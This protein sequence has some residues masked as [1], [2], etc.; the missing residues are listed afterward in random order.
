MLPGKGDKTSDVSEARRARRRGRGRARRRVA[1]PLA[2][3]R[4]GAENALE[5]IRL[6]RLT[7]RDGAHYEV[8]HRDH[9]YRLRHYVAPGAT[10][11]AHAPVLVLVPPLMLTAEI[12]D[13]APELSAV[14]QL[15]VAGVD[16]WV[17]DFGAP[18][19]EEG[20][21]QR[22][23]DD[24][25]RAVADAVGRVR[26]LAGRDVHL[27]GYSQG[28]M[29]AYQAAAFQ[30][31]EGIA[32]IIT[33]GSPVDIHR[34]VPA[35][36][37]ELTARVIRAVR[38]MIEAPLERM[39]GLPGVLTST[40]FKLLSPKKEISQLFDFV[41]K[42]HDRSALEKRETRRRFLA[43][44]GFVAWP[45]PALRQFIDEFIVHNRML[46]GGF[47]IDGRTVTLADIRCPVLCF[48][49]SR[50][51]IARPDAVRAI[52]RAAPSAELSE[53]T[54]PAG[55]FGL[56]VGS[57]AS[58]ETWPAVIEWLRWRDAG[59]AKPPRFASEE[60]G[61]DEPEALAEIED[62]AFEEPLDIE[63][64]YDAARGTIESAW[65]RLAHLI[66][67]AGD[68]LDH[69]RFQLP[70]LNQLGKM[71]DETRT[72]FGLELARQA[73]EIP[74]QTFFIWK[75]RAFSY[76]VADHRVDN[77]V[78]GL[79]HCG[80]RAGDHVGV[81]ME[82][83]P[84]YLTVVT[85]LNR[86][87]AIA[88]LTS[89]HVDDATLGRALHMDELA[90][91]VADPDHAARAHGVFPG[92]VLVLGGGSERGVP[93]GVVDMESI[94]PDAVALPEW[95]R[96]N[97]GRA[98]DVALIM[99]TAGDTPARDRA[100]RIT[101]RRWAFSAY[102][103]AAACTLTPKD[104]VYA[105]LPLHHPAGLLVSVGSAL[106]G[107]TRLAL[108]TR[109]DPQV[110]WDEVH[111]YGATV[112]YYAGELCREL[113]DAPPIA[114]E[115]DTPL[116]LFA[117]SGI[118]PDVWRQVLERFRGV[119]VLEF[120]ASTEV[121]LVLA[122]A[123]GE[124]IG[125]LGR[126]LPGSTELELVEYDFELDDFRRDSLGRFIRAANDE[127]GVLIAQVAPPGALESG[128]RLM[129]SDAARIRRSV[130]SSG[131]AWFVTKDFLR[132]DADGDYWFVD[133]L[134][135]LIRAARGVMPTRPLEEA[136]H[137][138]PAVA[139]AIAYGVRLPGAH[140]EEP[141]AAVVLRPGARLDLDALRPERAR[142]SF[143]RVVERIPMTDGYRLLKA[144]LRDQG[145][146]V[147]GRTFWLDPKRGR[148]VMLDGES[149]AAALTASP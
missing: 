76:K 47:V 140:H 141:V 50:D 34:N 1:A 64:F 25:V 139:L 77:V 144:P 55:H 97:P 60:R 24:H 8:A 143:V 16:A 22:T 89:P 82:G 19:R 69:L 109:F 126:P 102:G 105:C 12:Y 61:D 30:R 49:G 2:R 29:F 56:V 104:T 74:E 124:K 116:R 122:N 94:D 119:G 78:R 135:D 36:G 101:N 67:D 65:K 84:S 118:K 20:G 17:V 27:A 33:F 14:A 125:A 75:G 57:T 28:G 96:P 68:A 91:L 95:Y 63:L 128:E 90:L 86:I 59:G 149:Y 62:L 15:G 83:R 52:G 142:P 87:G 6:G 148:Y 146:V 93:P 80:V 114:G 147:D 21:M 4:A 39:E 92:T 46:S 26:E 106:V 111:R 103:A 138:L 115:R 133:R 73:R 38:P 58:R 5:V 11:A 121:N 54:V 110:F 42:L 70:R 13:V 71:E 99:I 98:A 3:A 31:S 48:V 130:F 108:A 112:V 129:G 9:M 145:I 41:K 72:S 37:A 88:V 127:A 53:L 44:E 35:L 32:S 117:G 85:A 132:R 7:V 136:L 100:A 81:V 10:T 51:E 40:G 123:A 137:E 134:R 107:G 120:Y 79:I 18:E 23:L 113:V 66:E 131:D 45:G 43:G